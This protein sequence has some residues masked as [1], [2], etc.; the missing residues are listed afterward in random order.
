MSK[1]GIEDAPGL[2]KRFEQQ[3]ERKRVRFVGDVQRIGETSE[4]GARAAARARPGISLLLGP[5]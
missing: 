3:R 2:E 5:I 4:A 1:S